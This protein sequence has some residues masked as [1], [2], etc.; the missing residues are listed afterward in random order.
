M[1]WRRTARVDPPGRT[2]SRSGPQAPSIGAGGGSAAGAGSARLRCGG[3]STAAAS[4]GPSALATDL[5][6]II[7]TPPIATTTATAAITIHSTGD[8]EP[9]GIALAWACSSVRSPTFG[10]QETVFPSISPLDDVTGPGNVMEMRMSAVANAFCTASFAPSPPVSFVMSSV[11]V[12]VKTSPSRT[13]FNASASPD[14]LSAAIGAPS[15]VISCP[16]NVSSS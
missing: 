2:P 11:P 4:D 1:W 3:A 10:D 15:N 8:D 9:D 13:I 6:R 12:T 16:M 14:P 7:I 5:R